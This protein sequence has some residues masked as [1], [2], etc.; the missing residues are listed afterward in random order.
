M[1][2]CTRTHVGFI[3]LNPSKFW[4]L[5]GKLTSTLFPACSCGCKHLLCHEFMI[6]KQNKTPTE[7]IFMSE[8]CGVFSLNGFRDKKRKSLHKSALCIFMLY[9]LYAANSYFAFWGNDCCSSWEKRSDSYFWVHRGKKTSMRQIANRIGSLSEAVL[10][11]N[12]LL[13]TYICFS[14]I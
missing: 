4:A 13:L 2:R 7:I 11:P 6:L 9:H 3:G 8:K 5:S 10:I 1:W 12:A 14:Q